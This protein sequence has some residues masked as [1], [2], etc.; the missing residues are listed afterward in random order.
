[1]SAETAAGNF[2]QDTFLE[3]LVGNKWFWVFSCALL[4]GFPMYKSMNR[5]LPPELPV[6]SK[7]PEYRFVDENGKTFGSHE[8]KG[9]IYVANFMFTSCQTSCPKLL[10]DVQ[11]IENRMKG[12]KDRAAIVSFTVDPENDT[13]KVLFDKAR[14]M[15]ANPA[16][17]KFLSS[18]MEETKKLLVEGFKVPVGE[19]EIAK[20]VM[21][22]A[23]S[24]RL[25]L[26]DQEGNIRGYYETEKDSVNQMMIDI[27]LLI[28]RKKKS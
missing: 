27:G 13:S 19:K 16:V 18:T 1:M 6:L 4:F 26:V 9:K 17:W 20:N 22:I 3:K 7:V 14:E 24:N 25:V 10:K 5:I 23:H 2:R 12:V 11:K 21:D 15:N 28:N 8:L